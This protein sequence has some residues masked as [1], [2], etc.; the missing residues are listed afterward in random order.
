VSVLSFDDVSCLSN[1][2]L[3]AIKKFLITNIHLPHFCK[4][5]ILQQGLFQ[6]IYDF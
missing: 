2:A 4:R 1:E 6:L 3:I 5:L